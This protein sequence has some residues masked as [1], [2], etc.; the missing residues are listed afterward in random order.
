MSR[1]ARASRR[2]EA[3]KEFDQLV[4]KIQKLPGFEDFLLPPSETEIKAAARCGPIVVINVSKYRCDALLVEP[5]QVQ[6]MALTQLSIEEVEDKAW[7]ADLGSH[8]VL[9]WLWD[10]VTQQILDA[11]GFTQPP[12]SDD[13]W[14]HVWWIPTGPLSKFP[15]H[16]AGHHSVRSAETVLDRVM[17]S[18][19]SSIKAII[20]GRRRRLQPAT[21]A[22]A[23]LIAM[24]H[25]PGNEVLPFATKEVAM[26]RNLC[27]SMSLQ[28]AEPGR[29]KQDIKSNLQDC[30]IFHFAGHGG[31]DEYDASNSR[32]ILEDGTLRVAELLE[33]NLLERSPFLAYLSA[34]G[35]GR[36]KDERST[37]ESIHLMSAFQLA[38]FRHVVG[39]LWE[40]RDELCVDMA[41]ITYEGMRDGAMT[42]E[43]VCRGLHHASRMLRDQY[44]KV[45]TETE[46]RSLPQE[47][48]FSGG[49]SSEEPK[50][51]QSLRDV[52]AFDAGLAPWAPYV[53]FGV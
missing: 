18:Y 38:G 33:M 6:A 4:A 13:S 50:G 25:T 46:D 44:L 35:T 19:A 43:S 15:L 27:R 53:H 40:V 5:H 20:H 29:R 23:L 36:I 51:A 21:S 32:L 41:R 9:E 37:D 7:G 11:L 22:Q 31:T 47:V 12:S 17:S 14:P 16:A 34:C 10:K 2:Y 39:T 49:T 52:G 1:Q 42:D 28:P 24:E 48:N 30:R 8:E 26:V 45:P 3:R